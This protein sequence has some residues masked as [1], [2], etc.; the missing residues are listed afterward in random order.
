MR[1]STIG[2]S[3]RQSQADPHAQRIHAVAIQGFLY[4]LVFFVLQTPTF[5]L[6]VLESQNGT[7]PEDEA[8]IFPI[9]LLQ[10]ILWP[11]QGFF[12]LLIYI[13]PSYKRA[14]AD[15]PNESRLWAFRRAMHGAKIQ[16]T[17]EPENQQTDEPEEQ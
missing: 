7:Y 4:V 6:R 1:G 9:L 5:I 13:R 17:D 12:N 16:P 10:N 3:R 2:N 11:M 14:R 8:K 15:F